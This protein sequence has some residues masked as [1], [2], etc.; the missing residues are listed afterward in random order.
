MDIGTAHFHT[1]S[2]LSEALCEDSGQS[3]ESFGGELTSLP[4]KNQRGLVERA[5]CPLP[6]EEPNFHSFRF[7]RNSRSAS[8]Q[9]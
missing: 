3:L 7:R 2:S 1:C 4:T 6:R 5:R 9:H 8:G